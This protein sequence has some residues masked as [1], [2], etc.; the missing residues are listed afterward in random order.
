MSKRSKRSFEVVS[1]S[2]LES[3]RIHPVGPEFSLGMDD[4]PYFG[5]SSENSAAGPS[6]PAKR[7]KSLSLKKRG[8]ENDPTDGSTRFEEA[9][10]VASKDQYDQLAK[11]FVP[12]TLENVPAGLLITLVSGAKKETHAFLIESSVPKIC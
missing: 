6:K 8:K 10:S 11:G 1:P 3:V 5:Y 4:F 12:K 9:F 7:Q 2:L